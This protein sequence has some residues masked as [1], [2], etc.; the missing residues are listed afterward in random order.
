MQVDCE[1]F[2]KDLTLFNAFIGIIC[3]DNVYVNT[4]QFTGWEGKALNRQLYLPTCQKRLIVNSFLNGQFK[5]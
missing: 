4:K 3:Q 2:Q 1:E 5:L